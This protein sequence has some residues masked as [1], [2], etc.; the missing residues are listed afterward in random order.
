MDGKEELEDMLKSAQENKKAIDDL[1]SN[2]EKT[3]AF[4]DA[5]R[6]IQSYRKVRQQNEE[7]FKK[8][9]TAQSEVTTEENT[10][11]DGEQTIEDKM[12][13]A[14]A[15][16]NREPLPLTN[17]NR[18][19]EKLI[20]QIYEV[21]GIAE[22]YYE[23][24]YEMASNNAMINMYAMYAFVKP[25]SDFHPSKDCEQALLNIVDESIKKFPE[26]KS[27]IIDL[28]Q[29]KAGQ[30]KDVD[31]AEISG[32][33]KEIESL[34]SKHLEKGEIAFN[35]VVKGAIESGVTL[36]GVQEA[37]Q[38]EKDSNAKDEKGVNRDE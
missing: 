37:D 4:R 7:Y 26:R 31:S 29:Y 8:E 27:E 1:E 2:P 28:L 16:Y 15:Y 36:E 3:E 17:G 14:V 12:A 33:R 38:A 24:D 32:L 30:L 21:H 11:N 18:P 25:E 10:K 22:S 13:E 20:M 5:M 34:I 23:N 9:E 35:S 6:S 19:P